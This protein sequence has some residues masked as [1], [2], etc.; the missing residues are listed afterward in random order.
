M[1]ASHGA[2]DLVMTTLKEEDIQR[3]C[4]IDL[5]QTK[6]ICSSAFEKVYIIMHTVSGIV[7]ISSFTYSIP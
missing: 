2:S 3:Y 6:K 5:S 1:I 4:S 7:F